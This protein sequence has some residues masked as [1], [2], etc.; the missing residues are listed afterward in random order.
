MINLLI[1][2]CFKTWTSLLIIEYV[3]ETCFYV[4]WLIIPLV[5]ILRV[6]MLLFIGFKM[7]IV[8]L[9][10]K[11]CKLCSK[12]IFD[13]YF[14]YHKSK[15][16]FFIC[17]NLYFWLK[18]SK[19]QNWYQNQSFFIIFLKPSKK[20]SIP[21]V[22]GSIPLWQIWPNWFLS[23]GNLSHVLISFKLHC[24]LWLLTLNMTFAYFFMELF[25]IDLAIL[26]LAF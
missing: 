6:F 9:I 3:H 5:D 22:I 21:Y 10:E 4:F 8:I 20:G 12:T 15:M 17:S 16:M 11:S 2:I 1:C 18:T 7:S 23:N 14:Y 24:T 19:T 25:F 26:F 13:P